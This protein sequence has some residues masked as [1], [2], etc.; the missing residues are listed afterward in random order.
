VVDLFNRPTIVRAAPPYSPAIELFVCYDPAVFLYAEV[1]DV[2]SRLVHDFA[3]CGLQ[4][5]LSPPNL[6][7]SVDWSRS[8]R[9]GGLWVPREQDGVVLE[10]R[11]DCSV[12]R[13][14]Q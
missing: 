9:A 13:H 6:T 14:R 12:T 8:A 5:L 2:M 10:R 3:R 1:F 11:L 7:V 4:T